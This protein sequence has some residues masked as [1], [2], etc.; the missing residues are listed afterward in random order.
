M[1][2]LF[3]W[4]CEI[5][6]PFQAHFLQ[7]IMP[8]KCNIR[9]LYSEEK[10]G[11]T[12]IWPD[13]C[14]WNPNSKKDCDIYRYNYSVNK[15]IGR[16]S[17]RPWTIFFQFFVDQHFWTVTPIET[18]NHSKT[19]CSRFNLTTKMLY[20][21]AVTMARVTLCLRMSS[22]LTLTLTGGKKFIVCPSLPISDIHSPFFVCDWRQKQSKKKIRNHS[23]SSF[24]STN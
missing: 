8:R 13:C 5:C 21:R 10:F 17:V 15:T 24:G 7:R 20:W 16:R 12:K 4:K 19:R 11:G 6:I 22:V 9:I 23:G 18:L 3:S 14:S 2:C 1:A